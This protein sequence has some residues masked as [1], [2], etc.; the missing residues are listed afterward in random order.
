MTKKIVFTDK[1]PA[2]LGPYSQ[3]VISTAPA[4]VF[5][6]GQLGLDPGDWR[7]GFRPI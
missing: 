6:S 7:I 5:I 2:A 3:A 4:T 1:A